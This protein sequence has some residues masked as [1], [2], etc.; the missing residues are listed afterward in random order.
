MA[1]GS[2]TAVVLGLIDELCKGCEADVSHSLLA[3]RCFAFG[4]EDERADL[5]EGRVVG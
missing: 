3:R 5:P 4:I 1:R 2:K